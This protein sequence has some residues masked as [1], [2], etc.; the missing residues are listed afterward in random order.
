MFN[1]VAGELT[2][3][4]CVGRTVTVVLVFEVTVLVVEQLVEEV[5]Q[6]EA[7]AAKTHETPEQVYPTPNIEVQ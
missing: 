7:G 1:R 2:G 4:V 5:V 3:K 6:V